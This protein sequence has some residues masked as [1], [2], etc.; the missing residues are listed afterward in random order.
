MGLIAVTLDKRPVNA[1]MNSLPPPGQKWEF[2]QL[3]GR[4]F[5]PGYLCRFFF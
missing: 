5:F 2:F 4:K 1:A 3:L